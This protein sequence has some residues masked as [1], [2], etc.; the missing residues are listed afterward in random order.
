[1]NKGACSAERIGLTMSDLI[2]VGE[3]DWMRND[4]CTDIKVGNLVYP[5]VEHAYQAAKFKSADVKQEIARASFKD[6]RRI[7]RECPKIRPDWEEVKSTVMETLVRQKFTND[8]ILSDRLIKTGSASIV[9]EGYDEYWGTGR[10]GDGENTLGVILETVRADLQLVDGTDPYEYD[11][12]D[13]EDEEDEEDESEIPTLKEAILTNPDEDLADTCQDLYVGIKSLMTL[14]DIKD[15]DARFVSTRT[16]VP[17]EVAEDAIK[18]LMGMQTAL[19]TLDDLLAEKKVA[20]LPT[21]E[22]DEDEEPDDDDE[23]DDA[24]LGPMD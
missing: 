5:S 9:M 24:W 23:P 17:L 19:S 22:D 2:V 4:Y 18:K 7:G 10:S 14:V 12:D 1:M 16:G 20:V 3:V 6:A 11:E 21:D 15:F 8:P 13:D